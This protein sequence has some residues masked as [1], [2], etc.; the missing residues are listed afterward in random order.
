MGRT[1][2][3]AERVATAVEVRPWRSGVDFT[4][5]LAFARDEIVGVVRSPHAEVLETGYEGVVDFADIVEKEAAVLRALAD[6]E[7]PAPSVI[8][9]ERRVSDAGH[10]WILLEHIVHEEAARLDPHSRSSSA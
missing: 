8:A 6:A 1:V 4:A 5:D 3:P 10:S 2:E 9:W 7:V